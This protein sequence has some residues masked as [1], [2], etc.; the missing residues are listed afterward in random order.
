MGDS[1]RHRRAEELAKQ[2]ARN[3]D[4]SQAEL[5][6][7]FDYLESSL[8]DD[9]ALEQVEIRKFA[10]QTI[11][12]VSLEDVPA[13]ADRVEQL[14]LEIQTQQ[15][16]L[17]RS[18]VLY[19]STRLLSVLK[20][21]QEALLQ[22]IS[23]I[24]RTK[25]SV[26]S[27]SIRTLLPVFT[28]DE[29]YPELTATFI[30]IVDMCA[31]STNS[32]VEID[33]SIFWELAQ[34]SEQSVQESALGFIKSFF[35]HNHVATLSEETALVKQLETGR[36][37]IKRACAELVKEVVSEVEHSEVH[38][39]R[40]PL[41]RQLGSP[42]VDV[43]SAALF[44]LLSFPNVTV[45]EFEA[46]FQTVVE[47]LEAQGTDRQ[48]AAADVFSDFVDVVPLSK[49]P[50][51]PLIPLLDAEDRIT[52]VS[53]K[54]LLGALTRV[55]PD[56][57]AEH[58]DTLVEPL[59]ASSYSSRRKFGSISILYRLAMEKPKVLVPVVPTIASEIGMSSAIH[60]SLH[61]RMES[62]VDVYTQAINA[63]P[64]IR[65]SS[66]TLQSSRVF[67]SVIDRSGFD[68]DEDLFPQY[69]ALRVLQLV[70]Q[71]HIAPVA[72]V[73]SDIVS[74]LTYQ[75]P[76]FHKATFSLLSTIT[77]S[78]ASRVSPH[79][80]YIIDSINRTDGDSQKLDAIDLAGI[81]VVYQAIIDSTE[82]WWLSSRDLDQF[83]GLLDVE[84]DRSVEHPELAQKLML[85][86]L[87]S[88]L[89]RFIAP[90]SLLSGGE[91]S[92][93]QSID[94]DSADLTAYQEFVQ[95]DE[96][97]EEVS[98]ARVRSLIEVGRAGTPYEREKVL[99]SL[100]LI[101]ASS[102]EKVV[103][104]VSTLTAWADGSAAIE[105]SHR[106]GHRQQSGDEDL[107]G[108][109]DIDETVD[110]NSLRPH[111][112]SDIQG[113]RERL[114]SL[115]MAI[116]IKEPDALV[117]V[118]DTVVDLA[119]D[120]NPEVS[121]VALSALEEVLL[122][123]SGVAP[124]LTDTVVTQLIHG[125]P[126][127]EE[128]A[129][130]LLSLL[131][132]ENSARVAGELSVVV[133]SL[134]QATSDSARFFL[135]RTVSLV[136]EHDPAAVIPV[137]VHLVNELENEGSEVVRHRSAGYEAGGARLLSDDRS[138]NAALVR[139]YVTRALEHALSVD[140]CTEEWSPQTLRRLLGGPTE[141]ARAAAERYVAYY[142]RRPGESLTPPAELAE[143]DT[144][145]LRAAVEAILSN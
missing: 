52:A 103:P 89:M 23:E 58:L 45:T 66:D 11:L 130:H 99:T 15:R 1:E 131:A 22:A 33:P 112:T 44:A 83:F 141:V 144:L 2:A 49:V 105:A 29:S 87:I 64:N 108:T 118:I 111:L 133:A 16:V 32:S 106:S 20:Q 4:L 10:A 129:A 142:E 85:R 17:T 88:L 100:Y 5:E 63:D 126:E 94:V 69:L 135:A 95:S 18:P 84:F 12:S 116:G 93:Q 56:A 107:S 47:A 134:K 37:P 55:K 51:E 76:R 30:R 50:V 53:A 41:E 113:V 61:D 77:D 122:E 27:G 124:F 117:P 46:E 62:H 24:A 110:L 71:E 38:H 119:R 82:T 70:A 96:I 8:S 9:P 31:V 115:F 13:I 40:R 90:S 79:L 136:A 74:G 98:E 132:S 143:R 34:S 57:V 48:K 91:D 101:A 25:P 128:E 92:D 120:G 42:H 104:H 67:S 139:K 21:A 121:R 81:Y 7:A 14:I 3:P 123:H 6:E 19:E 78:H 137:S 75:T 127:V 59:G 73:T 109:A 72:E 125:D 26:A 68:I 138:Q 86:V 60:D 43:H 145:E 80:G 140:D 28:A 54:I 39:L 65:R 35:E 36:P 97:D 114:S 102:H